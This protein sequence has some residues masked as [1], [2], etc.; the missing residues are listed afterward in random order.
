VGRECLKPHETS[1][2]LTLLSEGHK[3]PDLAADRGHVGRA[4][5]HLA[6]RVDATE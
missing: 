2:F 3:A 5:F 6:V 1:P 4:E